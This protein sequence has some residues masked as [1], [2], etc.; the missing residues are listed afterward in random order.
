M[1]ESES[2]GRLFREEFSR[3]VAVISRQFGLANLETAEDIVSESFLIA[4]REW[5]ENGLPKNPA[6]WLYTVAKREAIHHFRRKKILD[7]RVLPH[8]IHEQS[9]DD[10]EIDLDFT[11]RSI[12]DSQLQMIFAVCDPLIASEAQ[13]GLALRIL[14]G[15]SIEEIAEAFLTNKETIN[16]RLFRAKGKLRSERVQM[17]IPTDDEIPR[18]LDSV[19]RIVYL[20]FNEG[21][22]SKTQNDVLRH[23]LCFEAMR[24]GL[25]LAEN[26]ATNVPKTNALLALMCFHAS[27]FPARRSEN[28]I[29][30]YEEQDEN[31]WD[32]NLIVQGMRFL[33]LAAQGS[34]MTSYH[35]EAGIAYWHSIKEDTTEKWEKIL[36]LYDGLLADVYTPAAALNRIYA[37]AKVKGEKPAIRE[38]EN[39]RFEDNHFYFVLLGELYAKEDPLKAAALFQKALALAKTEIE[40]EGIQKKIA[41]LAQYP[42]QS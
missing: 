26:G 33:D 36:Q 28:G 37:L 13:I 9:L 16:K 41:R 32:Q 18:R 17:E 22:Y 39:L 10:N 14:C 42:G 7:T 35:Y 5:K 4:Q 1:Q 2:I 30:L 11:P 15:F 12:Q 19:L 6:G 21:Y 31:L 20:L 3:M 27:R 34:T 23:D 24:L 38:A 25:L 29:V 8:V 40:K